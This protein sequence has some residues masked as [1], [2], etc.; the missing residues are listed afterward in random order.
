MEET[1]RTARKPRAKVAKKGV[2]PTAAKAGPQVAAA[3][4]PARRKA[5]A[6]AAGRSIP[7]VADREARVRLA[8]YLRAERRGFAPGREWEDWLAAEAEV[9]AQSAGSAAPRG[10]RVSS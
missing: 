10:K 4:P 8:A 2:S 9:D 5:A 3:K 6:A 1:R 7:P